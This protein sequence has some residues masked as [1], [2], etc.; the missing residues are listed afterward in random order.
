[1]GATIER[2]FLSF[3]N[4]SY[5]MDGDVAQHHKE[6]AYVSLRLAECLGMGEEEEAEVVFAAGMHDVGLFTNAEL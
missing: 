2:W 1:M 6:T 3:M 4:L 5:L